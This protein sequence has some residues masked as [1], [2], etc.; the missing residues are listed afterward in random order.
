MGRKTPDTNMKPENIL[1][2][3][4]KCDKEGPRQD[5]WKRGKKISNTIHREK[6]GT[7]QNRVNC[8]LANARSLTN[9]MD[10]LEAEISTGN[11]DIVGIT[12]TWLDES[13]D[14]A[15]NLQRYSL[16]RRDRRNRKGGGV[17]LYVKT[18]LKPT[19]REDVWEG[20][21]EV[22][23]L[24]VEIHGAKNN[25][26]IIIGVC[27]KPPNIAEATE[28]LLM[29]QIDE[30]AK[31]NEVLIMGDF[32][33]PDI[34][35]ETESCRSQKGNRFLSII[36]DN[37]LSQLVQEPTRG[38]ALLDLI[39][40]NRPDRITEV[41]VGGHLG[42]SDHNII[43]FHMCFSRVP[44]KG[45]TKTLNF[46]RA[47]FDQLRDALH[48]IDWDSIFSNRSTDR[49]WEIFKTVL[50]SHCRR[51]IPY[52]N[53]RTRNRRKPMWLNKEFKRAMKNKKRAFGKL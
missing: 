36:K 19:I 49:K 42:N 38:T 24:W 18:C 6:I 8:V 30:V 47:K 25:N 33:Y 52:G 12:E 11:Y 50:H 37:Y 44:S 20:N 15:V 21:E 28:S 2:K 3:D 26:K 22:E 1:T 5:T 53:K 46:R 51:Y 13:Y 31:N 14:W 40:T 43:Q 45:V 9:K 4:M 48:L 41:Q 32:N 34:D 27:Y 16:F 35:W 17:C 39:L 7:K 23:S 29:R 10:E